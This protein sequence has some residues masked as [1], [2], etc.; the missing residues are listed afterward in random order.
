[1][2]DHAD[3]LA[4]LAAATLADHEWSDPLENCP[5]GNSD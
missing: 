5:E 4:A 3:D 2:D 1:M